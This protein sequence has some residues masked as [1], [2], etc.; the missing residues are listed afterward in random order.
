MH[1]RELAKNRLIEAKPLA[2]GGAAQLDSILEL[3]APEGLTRDGD[4]PKLVDT[5]RC[6]A[7]QPGRGLGAGGRKRQRAGL[8]LA[9]MVPRL[10]RMVIQPG[11]HRA[12]HRPQHQLQAHDQAQPLVQFAY[13]EHGAQYGR[14]GRRRKGSRCRKLKYS[15]HAP[16]NTVVAANSVAPRSSPLLMSSLSS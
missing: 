12:A 13:E 11:E 8:G 2:V 1:Q 7:R 15:S 5:V 4:Q 14:A 10:D 6:I 9:D 16:L 3:D